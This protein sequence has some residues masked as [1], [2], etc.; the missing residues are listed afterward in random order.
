MVDV[1]SPIANFEANVITG[2]APLTVQ[3]TDT[4]TDTP[5]SWVREHSTDG[6][7]WVEFSTEQS[8]EYIFDTVGVYSIRLTCSNL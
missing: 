3:F 8:P 5:T 1:P 6:E 7:T 2:N 4:S